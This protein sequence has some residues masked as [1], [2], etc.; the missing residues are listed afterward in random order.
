MAL[1][2]IAG[3]P[4]SGKSSRAH[5]LKAAL[6]ARIQGHDAPF[7]RVAILDDNALGLSRACYDESKL[8]KPARAALFTAIQRQLAPDTVLIVDSLNYIKGFRYQ[9]YC[10]A[11]EMKLRTCTMFVVANPELCRQWNSSRQDGNAYAEQTLDNLLVRF[12]EPSSMV[13]WDAPLFTVTSDD[14]D[15]PAAQIWEA[16]TKG[17]LKPPNSGTLAVAKAPAD[18]LHV[19]EQTTTALAS[20]IMSASAAQPTGGLTI[21]ATSSGIK[22]SITLPARHIT[23]SEL[24]RL[25]RQFVTVHKKAITLGTTERGGVDWSEESVANKFV[26]YVQEHL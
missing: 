25:K 22:A 14:D 10:A 6:D 24:Q 9:I 1:I 4:A 18:A 20:A 2:T 3:F 26:E 12:E 21:V 11:R 16:I 19:L 17:N 8:E 23:L 13:R 7:K 5:Q 15:V